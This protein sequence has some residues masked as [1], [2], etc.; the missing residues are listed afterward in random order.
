MLGTM[1]RAI[2]SINM[3]DFFILISLLISVGYF[4]LDN[5]QLRINPTKIF[6]PKIASSPVIYLSLL[7]TIY[8][9]VIVRKLVYFLA[10]QFNHKVYLITPISFTIAHAFL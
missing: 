10:S 8:S 9:V 1:L 6:S 7:T 5:R 2:Y 4:Y 3:S